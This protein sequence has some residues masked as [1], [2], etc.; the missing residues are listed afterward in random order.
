MYIFG[1]LNIFVTLFFI[2]VFG[3]FT[4]FITI[5]LEKKTIVANIYIADIISIY[6]KN[7]KLTLITFFKYIIILKDFPIFF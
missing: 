7:Y 2:T 3:K 6:S 1:K 4:I 5:L